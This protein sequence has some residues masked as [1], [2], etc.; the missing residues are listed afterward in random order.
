MSLEFR[1]SLLE[2]LVQGLESDGKVVEKK[3]GLDR[4]SLSFPGD[5]EDDVWSRLPIVRLVKFW[6]E[7]RR[8]EDE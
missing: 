1:K 6:K 4:Q 7:R 8:A 3:L 5:V 2:A